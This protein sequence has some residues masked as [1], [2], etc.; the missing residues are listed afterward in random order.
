MLEG[1][2]WK[3]QLDEF[4]RQEVGYLGDVGGAFL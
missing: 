4:D 1:W 2:F 3:S